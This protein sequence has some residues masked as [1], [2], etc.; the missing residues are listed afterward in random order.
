MA[1]AKS[2]S[3]AHNPHLLYGVSGLGADIIFASFR[4][5]RYDVSA[6]CLAG[7]ACGLFWYPIVWFTHGIYLYPPSFVV[8]DLAIRVVGSAAFLP[9]MATILAG[10]TVFMVLMDLVTRGRLGYDYPNWN[11]AI[12]LFF[13][14]PLAAILSVEWDVIVSSR[15]SDVRG[16][17]AGRISVGASLRWDLFSW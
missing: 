2:L 8:S 9:P 3:M 17:A 12:V 10:A 7:I 1:F 11:A 4:Y 15:V 16:R 13:M 6:V 14:V 5:K